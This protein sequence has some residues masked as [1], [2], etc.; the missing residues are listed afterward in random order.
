MGKLFLFAEEGEQAFRTMELNYVGELA[1]DVAQLSTGYTRQSQASICCGRQAEAPGSRWWPAL[2]IL[3]LCL[4][5]SV[6][7][8]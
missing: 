5:V 2:R 1:S 3:S 4:S 6:K 7:S 8:R